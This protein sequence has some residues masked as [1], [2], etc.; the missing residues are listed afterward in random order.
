MDSSHPEQRR[1]TLASELSHFRA[2][3][4]VDAFFQRDSSLQQR[5]PPA[6]LREGPVEGPAGRRQAQQPEKAQQVEH[7][8]QLL[9]E[10]QTA[11]PLCLAKFSL[12]EFVK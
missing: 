2:F 11:A 10:Q 6:T 5:L 4:I 9:G 3:E 12:L 8:Q 1:S 7:V